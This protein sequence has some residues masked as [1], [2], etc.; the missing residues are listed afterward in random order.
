MLLLNTL[1]FLSS[2]SLCQQRSHGPII[3]GSISI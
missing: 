1:K 3:L 2:Q